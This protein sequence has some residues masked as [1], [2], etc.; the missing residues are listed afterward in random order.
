ME[1][2][3]NFSVSSRVVTAFILRE[4]IHSFS[5]FL[6]LFDRI[7]IPTMVGSTLGNQYLLELLR[8]EIEVEFFL[9]FLKLKRSP[10]QIKSTNG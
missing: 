4:Q 6:E 7:Q 5:D 8:M 3:K 2:G 10:G 9:H 1:F